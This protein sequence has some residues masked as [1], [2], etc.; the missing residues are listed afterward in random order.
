MGEYKINYYLQKVVK[1]KTYHFILISV[2]WNNQRIRTT[3]KIN[4]EENLWDIR[5]QRAKAS[6]KNP[7]QIND[8][9]DDIRVKMKNYFAESE[10]ELN[11]VPTVKETKTVLDA[12]INNREFKQS[13]DKNDSK[14]ISFMRVFDLFIEDT[15]T[16]AR[17]S[18]S[19]KRIKKSTITSYVTTKNHLIELSKGKK[20]ELYFDD[21]NDTFFAN[22]TN[23]LTEK[24]LAN[25]SQGRLVKIVKTFM[26]WSLEKGFHNNR[27]FI[28]SLKI[29]DEKTTKIA[30]NKSELEA[31]ENITDLSP[32]LER[33][34]DMFLTQCYCGL[35]FSD[36]INLKPENI[37][38]EEK[39]ISIYTV[40]TKD[41]LIVPITTKLQVILK[42][43][44]SKFPKISSQKYN[45]AIKELCQ[46]AGMTDNIQLTYNIGSERIDE[47]KPKYE[48]ISSHTGRRT[49]ITL[50]L[51]RGLLEDVIMQVSGH[52]NKKSFQRYV[53]IAKSDAINEVRSAW[54][55]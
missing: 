43:Y 54:E 55:D 38:F 28:K 13:K 52:T 32:R 39:I 25:N 42:K 33:T 22:L 3:L 49:F 16:G 20:K 45:E 8:K 46:E 19:G 14:Q 31:I 47:I 2:A 41:P 29:F 11:R 6:S 50:S 51:R 37:N 21:I 30:L 15:T 9:L 5:K 27:T 7:R 36:L 18:G 17:L 40:K 1:E 4:I 10:K 23:Y 35:R 48:L 44:K 53:R 34:R 12:I 26:H 24:K